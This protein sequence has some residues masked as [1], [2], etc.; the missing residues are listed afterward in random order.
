MRLPR[1][2]FAATSPGG[3][4]K[5]PGQAHYDAGRSGPVKGKSPDAACGASVGETQL[6]RA[7]SGPLITAARRQIGPVWRNPDHASSR[8]AIPLARR[9]VYAVCASLTALGG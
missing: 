6:S 8:R 2:W 4:Q 1:A 9:Q 7:A 5:Q 3:S